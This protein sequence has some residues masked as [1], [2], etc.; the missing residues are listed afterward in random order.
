MNQSWEIKVKDK[1]GIQTK[2]TNSFTYSKNT[3]QLASHD[4]AYTS[5]GPLVYSATPINFQ[6]KANVDI[7]YYRVNNGPRINITKIR[8]I[9]IF[10]DYGSVTHFIYI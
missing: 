9:S 2:K 10:P 4:N 6:I 7:V 8:P 5:P 1:S 3:I